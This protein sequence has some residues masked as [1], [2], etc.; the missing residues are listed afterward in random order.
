M[1][2]FFLVPS[3]FSVIEA[4]EGLIVWADTSCSLQDVDQSLALSAETVD[5]VFCV[6]GN[7]SLEEE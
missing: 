6:V 5:D 4:Q 2:F 1:T 3:S 7:R